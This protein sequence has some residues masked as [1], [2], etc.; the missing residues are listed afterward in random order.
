MHGNPTSASHVPRRSLLALLAI[1]A[2]A[3]FSATAPL[4]AEDWTQFRGPGRLGVWHETGIVE[5]LP[6]Q[7]KVTW[8]TPLGGGYS[9]PAVADG[10]IFVAD[11]FEDPESRTVDGTERALALDEQ[12]GEILWTHEWQT[13]YRMLV[14]SYAVGPRATPTVDGDRVYVLGATG[15]LFCFDVETGAVRWEKDY[16]ADYDTSVPVYG[17]ASAPLVDGDRLIA[18]VGGEPDALVVAFDKHTGEEL[19]RSLPVRSEMG[20][21]HPVI[22]EAG[23]ARQLIIWHPEA[24]ASLDPET[25]EVYWEHAWEVPAAVSVATP[26]RS[27]DYLFV[28]QFFAGSMMMRLSGDRPA[29]TELWRGGSRSELPDQSEGLHALVTTPVIVGDT[30]YGVGSY[31]ELRGLDART[32][33]RLWM[34]R[35][36]TVEVRWSSAHLVQHEDRYF[37]N[38]DIGDLILARFTPTGYEELARTKLI[39]PTSS[40]GT[41]TPHGAIAERIVNWTHPAYANGHIVHRNDREIVRASL[42]A[43]DY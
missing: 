16:V 25:G 21:A 7:L 13:T 23:G 28:S 22:Y 42:R 15:R 19:W 9:G 26:V 10:R 6:E 8:R 43:S 39:E 40:S 37:V 3:A 27:G 34:S 38:N 4:L 20:Y 31:G 24:L 5:T 30:I 2:V 35:D 33:E 18:L 32:G 14:Y 17:V 11:W 41:R 12:T 1:A 29:A 36:M